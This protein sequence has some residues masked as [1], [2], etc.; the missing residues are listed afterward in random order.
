MDN[1]LLIEKYFS[2]ELNPNEQQ[3]L[4][5]LLET[6]ADFKAEFELQQDVQKAIK[7]SEREDKK[8]LLE[9]YEKDRDI[10]DG[11]KASKRKWLPIAA[12]IA[13]LFSLGIYI[14][15]NI[16]PDGTSL[17]DEYY[18]MYPNTVYSI[19]RSGGEESIERSAF[20]A[21]EGGDYPGAIN[22]FNQL[23]ED[24]DAKNID[25]YIGQAY[26]ANSE[27]E[28]AIL[29]FNKVV[30]THE[31]FTQESRWYLALSYLKQ[32]DVNNAKKILTEIE[33]KNTYKKEAAIQLL[34]ALD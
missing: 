29:A 19:T 25:F 15:T 9:Q 32:E 7:L 27:Y 21:Y 13:L 34:K 22:Y 6:D 26:L 24:K 28:N 33:Q 16:Q 8:N 30:K 12:A 31:E 17:Y 5:S 23:K 1:E 3:E 10:I 4:N 14:G 2:G 11:T 18:E 20:E